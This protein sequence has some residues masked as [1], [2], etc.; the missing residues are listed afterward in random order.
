VIDLILLFI[1]ERLSIIPASRNL[2]SLDHVVARQPTIRPELN[3]A[4][5]VGS[6]NSIAKRNQALA[7]P[8]PRSIQAV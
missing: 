1:P 3:F 5:A 7:I 6:Q 4:R 2:E 8:A